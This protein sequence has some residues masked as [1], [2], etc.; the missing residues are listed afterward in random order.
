MKVGRTFWGVA[1]LP[2]VFEESVPSKRSWS[3]QMPFSGWTW[4]ILQ[5]KLD[6]F[7]YEHFVHTYK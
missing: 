2:W 4:Q 3:C 5:L 7:N 1:L 6:G